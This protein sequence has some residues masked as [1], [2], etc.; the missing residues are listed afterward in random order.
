MKRTTRSLRCW[1]KIA[2]SSTR[3]PVRYSSTRRSTRTTRT[4]QPELR[5]WTRANRHPHASQLLRHEK[6]D[7]PERACVARARACG[8]GA[9]AQVR[10]EAPEVVEMLARPEQH[11]RGIDRCLVAITGSFPHAREKT[12][13]SLGVADVR[14]RHRP[15]VHERVTEG[16]VPR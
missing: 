4:Q 1:R 2:T 9:F 5:E 15:P 8:V 6:P 14:R 13:A 10:L 16:H 3:S 12:P 7:L 11:E